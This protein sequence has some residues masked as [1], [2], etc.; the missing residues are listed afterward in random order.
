[1]RAGRGRVL[2]AG[3]S[4]ADRRPAAQTR[5]AS[6]HSQLCRSFCGGDRQIFR[7]LG[8]W[9]KNVV[10]TRAGDRAGSGTQAVAIVL[11]SS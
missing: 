3:L 9:L 1:M 4:R 6:P 5:A 7:Q 11:Q 8:D 10:V 2:A